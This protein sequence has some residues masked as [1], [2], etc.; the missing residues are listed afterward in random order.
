[1]VGGTWYWNRYPGCRV[2]TEAAIYCYS[3]DE[4]LFRSWRWSE[5]YPRQPEVLAYLNTVADRHDLRRSIRFQTRIVRAEWDEA[6]ALWQ[7]TTSRGDKVSARYVF[8]GVG[9]LSSTNLP[10]FPGMADFR[11]EI[12][13]AARW[14][15]RGVDL[16]G[17]RVAVIGTGSTGIQIVT[18]I[19]PVVAHLVVL[20]RTPQYVVPLGCG[21]FPAATR[22]RM[23]ADPRGFVDWALD[24]AAVFGLDESTTPALSVSAEE[25]AR[26]YERAWRKGGG[27]GFMLETFG[28]LVVS[29]EA[30]DTATA[31]IRAK[32]RGIVR[33]PSVA[34]TLCPHD[35][36]AKRPL[37]VDGYYETFNRDNVT[38]VDVKADPVVGFTEK[39][40][41]TVEREIDVDVVIL[42]TGFDAVTGNY[43]KIET[44]G[45]GGLRLQDKW[46][47]GP[48]GFIGMTIAGFPNLFMIF[49]P[50]GPFTSQ[51]LVHEWQIDWMSD[52][53]AHARRQGH[54]RIDTDPHAEAAWVRTCRDG[55]AATLF[56]QVDSWIT[57]ANVPGKPRAAMF[58]MGGM[59]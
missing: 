58:Y 53:V 49:G 25:R 21:P 35:L 40:V 43:L 9:L 36:Y 8:E 48:E 52:L 47:D 29:R 20:Q 27:F 1:D 2:D 39:G 5:R 19:A 50:F 42:A 34:E 15:A 7:L 57:G 51:P 28:D 41:R 26:V 45:R 55:M 11:G 59:K 54:C 31:F 3:F 30:N 56:P 10:A 4:E 24:S 22:A 32:I 17:K 13:H 44:I 6:A 14:P 23:D 46:A 37:A 12:H 33:D 38:L 18:E 16:A